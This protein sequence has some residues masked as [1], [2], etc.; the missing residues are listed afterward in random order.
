MIGSL[1]P[2]QRTA[3]WYRTDQQRYRSVY[4]RANPWYRRVARGVT[5]LAIVAI[6]GAGLYF[7]AHAVQDYLGRDRLPSPGQEAASFASTSFLIRS[8]APAPE[9]DGTITLDTATG[10]FEFVGGAGGPQSGIEI[11]SPDGARTYLRANGGG[12]RPVTTDDPDV[13][14]VTR[15][16]PYLLAVDDADDILENR[17]RK[18]YVELIDQTTEG[19]DRDSRERYEMQLDTLTYGSDYPLQWQTY[20]ETV[21]PG[22]AE[23]NDVPLTMWIDDSNVVVRLR[24]EQS[25]WTWE[26]LAYSD[27]RFVPVDPAAG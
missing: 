8:E 22:M 27:Q 7:G 2:G 17:L 16:I 5:G 23:A 20:R 21:V 18:G 26:R 3:A 19:A 4:K 24:D 6:V 9:V 13:V 12:W 15:T 11:V 10:S 1:A 14:A 25:N